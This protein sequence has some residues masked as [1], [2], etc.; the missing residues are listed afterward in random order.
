M[1]TNDQ[2]QVQP[3]KYH[4]S[5]FLIVKHQ[6]IYVGNMA[7]KDKLVYFLG[8]HLWIHISCVKKALCPDEDFTVRHGK[9]SKY[10]IFI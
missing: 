9:F 8:C 3:N 1:V 5:C 2:I 7:K 6:D 4:Q 10:K